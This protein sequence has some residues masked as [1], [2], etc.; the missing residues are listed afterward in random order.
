MISIG[1]LC[2]IQTIHGRI[3]SRQGNYGQVQ[4]LGC[5]PMM[6]ILKTF[7]L[8]SMLMFKTNTATVP[9]V[10]ERIIQLDPE[11]ES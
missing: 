4:L 6:C 7:Q 8:P 10:I 9:G 5:Y 11:L 3:G 1:L 2:Y